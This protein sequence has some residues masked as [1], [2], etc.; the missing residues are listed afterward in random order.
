[1]EMNVVFTREYVGCV[2]RVSSPYQAVGT[3]SEPV[4]TLEQY[5]NI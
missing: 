1:M 3:F 4:L 5:Y 2:Y